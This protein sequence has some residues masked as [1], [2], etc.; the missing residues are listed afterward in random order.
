MEGN[1]DVRAPLRQGQILCGAFVCM[2]PTTF[3]RGMSV[4]RTICHWTIFMANITTGKEK[5]SSSSSES[6]KSDNMGY[7]CQQN[8]QAPCIF[9]CS[10]LVDVGLLDETALI[11]LLQAA[12]YRRRE[13]VRSRLSFDWP[14]E[15]RHA[16]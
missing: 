5:R 10:P 7:S 8:R 12:R 6:D 15:I 1:V 11:Q 3:A 4:E 9:V 13:P 2:M 14:S 16:I